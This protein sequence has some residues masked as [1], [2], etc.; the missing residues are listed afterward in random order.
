MV[1]L[2]LLPFKGLGPKCAA[3]SK[4]E[5]GQ[6]MKAFLKDDSGATAIEYVLIGSAMGFALLLVMPNLASVTTS[7]YS[8]LGSHI[9]SGK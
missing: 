2:S 7:R 1:L 6:R 3:I 5:L 9:I 4:S 8:S